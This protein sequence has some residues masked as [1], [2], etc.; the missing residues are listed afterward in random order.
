M[1]DAI[2]K[3]IPLPQFNTEYI[4]YIKEALDYIKLSNIDN[5]I[6]NIN[7]DT[8]RY[9]TLS[10]LLSILGDKMSYAGNDINIYYYYYIYIYYIKYLFILYNKYKKYQTNKIL[11]DDDITQIQANI[12]LFLKISTDFY[13]LAGADD[14]YLYIN[15]INQIIKYILLYLIINFPQFVFNYIQQNI[16]YS[17]ILT[18]YNILAAY[19]HYTN[20]RNYITNYDTPYFYEYLINIHIH[21]GFKNDLNIILNFTRNYIRFFKSDDE[22]TTK[23][24]SFYILELLYKILIIYKESNNYSE[25]LDYFRSDINQD[26]IN[27]ITSINDAYTDINFLY[28]LTICIRYFGNIVFYYNNIDVLISDSDNKDLLNECTN[29]Y[30]NL[31]LL[32]LQLSNK[33]L[34]LSFNP[35]FDDDKLLLSLNMYLIAIKNQINLIIFLHKIIS[36]TSESIKNYGFY[37]QLDNIVVHLLSYTGLTNI[38]KNAIKSDHFTKILE[39]VFQQI[40]KE[41]TD[42]Y[43]LLINIL[44]I[45]SPPKLNLPILEVV[46][47][48]QTDGNTMYKIL[49]EVIDESEITRIEQIRREINYK[50]S[51]YTSLVSPRHKIVANV[52]QMDVE[53]PIPPT[54]SIIY[55]GGK[56][57]TK[58]K[59]LEI[60][61]IYDYYYKTDDNIKNELLEI[62][63]NDSS[64]IIYI[65]YL[66]SQNELEESI[67]LT[68]KRLFD[69]LQDLLDKLYDSDVLL[70]NY[71]NSDEIIFYIFMIYIYD[72]FKGLLKKASNKNIKI[73]ILNEKLKLNITENYVDIYNK[74]ENLFLHQ[75]KSKF[76]N[77]LKKNLNIK[78]IEKISQNKQS[79]EYLLSFIY[80]YS[81]TDDKFIEGYDNF[82]TIAYINI[83]NKITKTF[84]INSNKY[85]NIIPTLNIYDFTDLSNIKLRMTKKQE[86]MAIKLLKNSRELVVLLQERYKPRNITKINT[87]FILNSVIL[88]YVNS[89]KQIKFLSPLPIIYFDSYLTSTTEDNY[90]NDKIEENIFYFASK[91]NEKSIN[92]YVKLVRYYLIGLQKN[93]N[94][95]ILDFAYFVICNLN[96]YLDKMKIEDKLVKELSKANIEIDL[97]KIKEFIKPKCEKII[98]KKAI[99]DLL[100]DYYDKLKF[101]TMIRY[102]MNLYEYDYKNRLQNKIQDLIIVNEN[103]IVY[104]GASI[105]SEKKL[106]EILP[107][108]KITEI[109]DIIKK[110]EYIFKTKLS[111][112]KSFNEKYI[113]SIS[114]N[115]PNEVATYK[116]AI[117]DIKTKYETMIKEKKG[118]VDGIEKL[119]TNLERQSSKTEDDKKK[120]ASFMNDKSQ[121]QNEIDKN[122]KELFIID[123]NIQTLQKITS[124]KG[125]NSYDDYENVEKYSE[126]T[127]FIIAVRSTNNDIL[128]AKLKNLL[129]S[130]KAKI[131]NFKAESV[132]AELTKLN[133]IKTQLDKFILPINSMLDSISSNPIAQSAS[134]VN[135]KLKKF[136][137][138]NILGSYEN[139]PTDNIKKYL[140]SYEEILKNYDSEL[141]YIIDKYNPLIRDIEMRGGSNIIGN[142]K[143]GGKGAKDIA[144]KI[145]DLEKKKKTILDNL[146]FFFTIMKKIKA[147]RDISSNNEKKM[148]TQGFINENGMNVFDTLIENYDDNINNKK[149]PYEMAQNLFYQKANNLNLDPEEELAITTND[150]IIFCVVVYVVRLCTLYVCYHFVNTNN[151]KD[152]TTA[153]KYYISWYIIILL[154][155]IVAI[156]IDAFK[157]RILFNYLNMHI[158]SMGILIHIVLMLLF[159]YLIYLMTI[160][161]LGNEPPSIELGQNEKIKLQYKLEL[162]SIIIFI[163]ICILVFIII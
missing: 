75:D 157:L 44:E 85:E 46:S 6:I 98:D 114:F 154:I 40:E 147:N 156:N 49:F 117:T 123:T 35:V 65:L 72:N 30:I 138:K 126:I 57:I 25:I 144:N 99:L 37:T 77:F 120:I 107:N 8:E 20:H 7:N 111:D 18:N 33:Y 89:I 38:I 95:K 131:T 61:D 125:F 136:Y 159:G 104:G 128:K 29:I 74:L 155:L 21:F 81:K 134:I 63:D 83:L 124:D 91:E 68:F 41:Y 69:N 3:S 158:N 87:K 88:D 139:N 149:V 132:Q 116:S 103:R 4:N 110:I 119:I 47:Y 31:N 86:K 92:I 11:T 84:I 42:Y 64:Y 160:N 148:A 161:I 48:Q 32:S 23:Y 70:L 16:Q 109:E 50:I 78:K 51:Y 153:L 96:T 133:E 52:F 2:L 130:H 127:S 26:F 59:I 146:K 129:E 162:L 112:I 143:L 67:N 13:T 115:Y 135:D 10:G 80:N 113:Q 163:F 94:K 106:Q 39:D 45:A 121:Y 9:I 73:T 15:Q 53:N 93:L 5:S 58:K 22:T 145:A 102:L 55:F 56:N 151:I 90:E 43:D 108:D 28:I 54:N 19:E 97:R 141:T 62:F 100:Y 66:I 17:N 24:N 34:T 152:I 71:Y 14:G 137:S 1:I 105:D 36:T 82:L 118:K 60:S 76:I 101:E 140:E 122:N 142:N 150:K 27:R 12:D 79:T